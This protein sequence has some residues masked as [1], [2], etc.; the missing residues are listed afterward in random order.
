MRSSS[1]NTR[2][3]ESFF[4]PSGEAP[5]PFADLYDVLAPKVLRHFERR[6]SDGERAFDLAAETFAKAF[7]KRL[8][9][10]GATFEQAAAWIWSIARNELARFHRSTTVELAAFTRVGLERP[11]LGDEELRSVEDHGAT[12]AA[13]ASV[14][15]ALAQLPFDQRE[16]VRLYVVEELSYAEVATRLGVTN[17]VARARVSRALRRMKTSPQLAAAVELLER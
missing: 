4:A 15:S 10:R 17:D 5:A 11:P 14:R 6:V 9:F 12:Q 1:N 3:V 13:H 8:E 7:E 2:S 16:A